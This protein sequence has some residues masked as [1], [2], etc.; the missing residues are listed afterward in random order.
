MGI[1]AWEPEA[2]KIIKNYRN[3]YED[4][5]KEDFPLF[6]YLVPENG[7]VT[8]K[9]ANK[10]KE[11]IEDCIKKNERIKTPEDYKYRLY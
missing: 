10:L 2:G 9:T 7:T 6:E 11:L 5:F 8:L 3:K 1:L 4:H